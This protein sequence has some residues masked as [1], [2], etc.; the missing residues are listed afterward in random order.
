M[1]V[2]KPESDVDIDPRSVPNLDVTSSGQQSN[3]VA[4]S[5]SHF[6]RHPDPDSLIR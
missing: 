6:V 4:G 1:I 5:D 3:E 2:I